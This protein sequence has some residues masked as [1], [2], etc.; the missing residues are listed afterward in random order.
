MKLLY[1]FCSNFAVDPVAPAIFQLAR[2]Y[3]S[4]KPT[5]YIVGG[6]KVLHSQMD[7]HELFFVETEQ[8]PS[9]IYPNLADELNS[10]FPDVDM[11]GLINWHTGSNAPEKIFCAHSTADV[12]SG[13][14]APTSG[15][16]LTAILMAIEEERRVAGLTDYRTLY[17]ASH[18]SGLVY[19]REVKEL[20]LLKAPVFDIEIGSSPTDW[21][22]P[23]A[24]E[25]LAKA[26]GRVPSFCGLSRPRALYLGGI[27]FEPSATEIVFQNAFIEHHL[28]NQW[29]VSGEYNLPGAEKKILDAAKSCLQSPELIVFHAGLKSA[30]KEIVRKAAAVLGIPC[31]SHKQLRIH[32]WEKSLLQE[33]ITHGS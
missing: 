33:N 19:G 29:L 8:F 11:I 6:K 26:L 25:A 30:Y 12:P 24:H 13:I 20:T 16:F 22:H 17:E 1:L 27:H 10:Q 31:L 2:G 3:Y 23:K 9:T 21:N 32:G 14:F 18:W 4:A 5:S 28:P 7:E 15:Q